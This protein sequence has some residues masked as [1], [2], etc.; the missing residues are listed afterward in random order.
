VGELTGVKSV[1]AEQDTRLVTI[2]F[3]SPATKEQIKALMAEIGYPAEA[4]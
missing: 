1:K 2:M 3:D 4:A